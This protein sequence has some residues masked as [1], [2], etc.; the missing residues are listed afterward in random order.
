M[1]LLGVLLTGC[2]NEAALNVPV[3]DTDVVLDTE[4]DLYIQEN[5]TDE[6]NMAIRYRFV[7]RYV[8]AQERA[9]PPRVEVV[10][11]MLDFIEEFWIEPYMEV[12]NGEEYFRRFVPGEIVLLGGPIFNDDG[13]IVLGTADAG[14]QITFTNVNAIDPSDTD[15]RDLQLQTVYHEFAHVMHQN[16]RL[17]NAFET[18][19]PAGYT[20]PGSWFTLTDEEALLRG[21]VSPY[22]TS[23][24]NEDFAETVAFFLFAIDFEE[25]FM[26]EEDEENCEDNDCASRNQGRDRIRQKLSSIKD[27]YIKETGVSLDDLRAAVQSRLN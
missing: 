13:T 6:Y 2:T 5:F 16:F 1:L 8:G 26:M 17:P 24:P 3:R 11:P 12:E 7:D 9:T 19:S 22:S 25:S 15:W 10:R 21:F 23:S 18:I 20:S 4:L 14:A 27:H